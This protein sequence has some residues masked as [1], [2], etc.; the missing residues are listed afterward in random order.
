[1]RNLLL[2]AVIALLA[3][4]CQNNQP[5]KAT[6]TND[7][8]TFTKIDAKEIPDN[9]VK[10]MADDWMLITAG[11]KEKFNT[12]TASWGTLGHLWN[13]PVAFAFIR[14]QRYTYEFTEASDLFTL[15]FFDESYKD[16]LAYL[17]SVS[18]RDVNKVEKS[19]LTPRILES[20][21]VAFE[22]ARLIIECRKIYAETF[23]PENFADTSIASKI[24]PT[25]DFH[26]MYI[27]EI[28][29]VWMKK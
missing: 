7:M 3:V 24:Y 5:T 28:V 4:A 14:P 13:K 23:K 10:L 17:G 15:S 22:Q 26:K 20:G 6:T 9:V 19:G 8:K 18:G 11:T 2:C 27:G 29:N 1:M 21:T 25:K 16:T 12:M